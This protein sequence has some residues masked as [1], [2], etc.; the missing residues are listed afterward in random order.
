M[1]H[2]VFNGQKKQKDDYISKLEEALEKA[3]QTITEIAM[4]P[5]TTTTNNSDNRVNHITNNFDINDISR[6]TRVLDKHLTTDVL[7]QGQEGV[8]C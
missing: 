4:Q 1:N 2:K 6:I 7:R 3:N 8:A 5:K